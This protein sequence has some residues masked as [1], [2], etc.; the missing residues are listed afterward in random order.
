MRVDKFRIWLL[1]IGVLPFVVPGQP[2]T[3]AGL[4]ETNCPSVHLA[5]PGQVSST[6]HYYLMVY[7]LSI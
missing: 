6:F 4:L 7:L 5:L 2:N 3:F 1:G